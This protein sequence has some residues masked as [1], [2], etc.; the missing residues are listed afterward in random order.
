MSIPISWVLFELVTRTNLPSFTLTTDATTPYQSF[1]KWQNPYAIHITYLGRPSTMPQMASKF[2]RDGGAILSPST[3][4]LSI[5]G[6]RNSIHVYHR[7]FIKICVASAVL[8][9]F[10]LQGHLPAIE[11]EALWP[12]EM[13]SPVST[14][15]V[16]LMC[17]L[18]GCRSFLR[19][20]HFAPPP[21]IAHPVY[22]S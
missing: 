15:Q 19:S 18:Q 9:A 7:V 6:R 8:V 1:T 14:L 13:E 5:R 11:Q 2:P 17:A 22:R 21:I 4:H 20:S 3:R 12:T 10:C 16:G